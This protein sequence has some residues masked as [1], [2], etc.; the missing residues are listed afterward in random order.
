MK[1]QKQN[2]FKIGDK[3][4]HFIYRNGVITEI[5]NVNSSKFYMV[6]YENGEVLKS[7]EKLLNL[8]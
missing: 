3:V 4:I 8:Q 1:K 5:T 2:K 6:K 7:S